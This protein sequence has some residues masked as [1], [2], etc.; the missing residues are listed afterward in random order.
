MGKFNYG[1]SVFPLISSEFDAEGRAMNTKFIGTCFATCVAGQPVI[2]SAKHVLGAFE[3]SKAIPCIIT[4]YG[5]S[6]ALR[7]A[8][9]ISQHKSL[10]IAF[11]VLAVDFWEI[12][13]KE[14]EPVPL[15]LERLELGSDVFTFGFPNSQV[16]D[17]GSHSGPILEVD[18]CFFKGYVCNIEDRSAIGGTPHTYVLNFP[19]MPG[20]SGSP[21]LVERDGTVY[22]AG[23]VL[24]EKLINYPE[25]EEEESRNG[26]RI[27]RIYHRTY[28]FGLACDAQALQEIES[29]L[30]RARK[31]LC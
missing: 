18:Q 21:I 12:Y 9:I 6:P 26:E 11:M 28:A 7:L 5:D 2:I 17:D 8:G 24:K 15:L 16:L 22:C 29:V 19:A 1:K 27:R 20:A 31:D 25:S 3:K 4:R 23:I 10:D 14:F 13:S 30:S